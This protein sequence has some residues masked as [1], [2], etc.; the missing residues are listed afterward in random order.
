LLAFRL[1]ARA[2]AN[3]L[4]GWSFR[5]RDRS[6]RGL[7]RVSISVASLEGCMRKIT[8]TVAA[9]GLIALTASFAPYPWS[10]S[11]FVSVGAFLAASPKRPAGEAWVVTASEK[12]ASR[13]MLVRANVPFKTATR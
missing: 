10:G 12:I 5:H 8:I 2:S 6:G 3:I 13:P 11:P 7:N 9:L 4:P 1:A